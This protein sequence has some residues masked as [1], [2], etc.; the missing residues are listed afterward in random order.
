MNVCQVK[1]GGRRRVGELDFL[2][3]CRASSQKARDVLG[4]RPHRPG[5]IAELDSLPRPLDLSTVDPEPKRQVAAG[6]LK[7]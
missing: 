4:W 1:R 7:F 6:L 2:A 5:V 3:N